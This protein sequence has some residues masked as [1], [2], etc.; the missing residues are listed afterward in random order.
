MTSYPRKSSLVACAGDG[1]R[2]RRLL[3][4]TLILFSWLVVPL[5]ADRPPRT[6]GDLGLVSPAIPSVANSFCVIELLPPRMEFQATPSVQ[7]KNPFELTSLHAWFWLS[8]HPSLYAM[9]TE[10]SG[11]SGLAL[12]TFTRTVPP[13]WKAGDARFPLRLYQQLMKLWWRQT[14]IDERSA[15]PIMA[16]RLRGVA[17]QFALAMKQVRWDHDTM[18]FREMSGDELLSQPGSA[19]FTHIDGQEVPAQLAGARVLYDA[20]QEEFGI[21]TQDMSSQ[22]LTA[23]TGFH[24]GNLSLSDY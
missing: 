16:G 8:W 22:S 21:H 18:S 20:L 4:A 23:F 19:L 14:T 6:F 24:Q 10:E 12:N 15:G 17:L 3:V 9:S 7:L 2:L 13:G 5:L 1:R 11:G